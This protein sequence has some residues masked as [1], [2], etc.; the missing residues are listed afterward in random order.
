MSK[1]QSN[2]GKKGKKKGK[3]KRVSIR[4]QL[5][6]SKSG[7]NIAD[8]DVKSDPIGSLDSEWYKNA[9]EA[10]KWKP[11]WECMQTLMG[12]CCGDSFGNKEL[13]LK[14]DDNNKAAD[15]ITIFAKW[16]NDENHIFT[17]QHILKL[18]VPFSH[19][20]LHK[21]HWKKANKLAEGIILKQW[22]EKKHGFL[23]LVTPA[24]IAVYIVSGSQ[25]KKWKEHLIQSMD[26]PQ[27]QVRMSCWDFLSKICILS[28]DKTSGNKLKNRGPKDVELFINDNKIISYLKNTILNDKEKDV[29][30]SCAKFIYGAKQICNKVNILENAYKEILNDK[31]ASMALDIAADLYKADAGQLPSDA[32]NKKK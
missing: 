5:R 16:L 12:Y 29:R 18:L 2:R 17:R 4:D 24:L 10:D 6:A 28:K 20:Y 3:S 32:I 14:F 19:S 11:K 21:Q 30:D 31:R 15:V 26:S 22:A 23:Q 7:E 27:G 9:K 13:P 1:K 8:S 25:L